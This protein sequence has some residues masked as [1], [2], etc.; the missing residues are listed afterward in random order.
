M[1]KKEV[2]VC[3]VCNNR[4]T[5]KKCE[6]CKKDVCKF[7]V[8]ILTLSLSGSLGNNSDSFKRKRII[9]LLTCRNCFNILNRATKIKDA[10][11]LLN[12]EFLM[13]MREKIRNQLNKVVLSE[14]LGEEKEK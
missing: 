12:N 8:R 5:D 13:E 1:L 6:I 11:E 14:S 2:N 7:C 9:S 3:D 4:I 10:K